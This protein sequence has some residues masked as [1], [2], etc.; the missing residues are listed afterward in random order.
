MLNSELTLSFF[1]LCFNSQRCIYYDINRMYNGFL[2]YFFHTLLNSLMARRPS[3]Y[4]NCHW[5]V[6]MLKYNFYIILIYKKK[7]SILKLKEHDVQMT[8]AASV[9]TFRARS[10]TGLSM[11]PIVCLTSP[12]GPNCS[13]RL[14][15]YIRNRPK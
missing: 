14:N 12:S 7:T 6:M 15:K 4:S 5:L 1:V 2:S 11:K 8:V 10:T 3:V 13:N 9:P